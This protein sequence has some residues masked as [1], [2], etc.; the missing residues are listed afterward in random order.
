MNSFTESQQK[1]LDEARKRLAERPWFAGVCC[2]EFPSDQK[3]REDFDGA[4]TQL[5]M[6]TAYWD[7]PDFWNP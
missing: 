5:E 6:A 3:C 4:V 7:A 1:V 2:D